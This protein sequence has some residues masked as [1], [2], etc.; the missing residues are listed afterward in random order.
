LDFGAQHVR[1]KEKWFDGRVEVVKK[2][3]NPRLVQ[4]L[5]TE[6]AARAQLPFAASPCRIQTQHHNEG[7]GTCSQQVLAAVHP[8]L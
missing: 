1:R 5:T 2:N 7:W 4:L 3:T 6:S 8:S